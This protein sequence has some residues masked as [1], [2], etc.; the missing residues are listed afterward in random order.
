MEYSKQNRVDFIVGKFSDI[1]S[2]I[3]PFF[4]NYP[5]QGV[6]S[7][8][9]ADFCRVVALLKVKAHLTP[10]GLDQIRVIKALRARG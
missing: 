8:D 7:A 5:V 4:T 6:K 9:F 3:I 10:E 2:N 1:E